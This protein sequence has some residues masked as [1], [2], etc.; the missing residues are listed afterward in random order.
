MTTARITMPVAPCGFLVQRLDILDESHLGFWAL[1]MFGT[2][3]SF[4]F[5]PSEDETYEGAS[6]H[7]GDDDSPADRA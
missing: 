2:F 4:T 3:L 7:D 1:I 5:T 6:R